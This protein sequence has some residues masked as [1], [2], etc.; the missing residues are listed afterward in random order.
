MNLVI[1]ETLRKQV[2]RRARKQGISEAE[3]IH[4]A[5]KGALAAEDG[6]AK[7]MQL[8]DSSSLQ[9]FARFAKQHKV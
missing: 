1:S 3:Y 6:V 8:W 4:T 2:S 5:I 7:E 9:D